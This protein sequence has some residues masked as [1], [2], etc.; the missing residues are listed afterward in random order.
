MLL[1]NKK[2]D[3]KTGMEQIIKAET[4]KTRITMLLKSPVQKF[5]FYRKDYL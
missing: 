4:A 3:Q 2:L 1:I 5:K